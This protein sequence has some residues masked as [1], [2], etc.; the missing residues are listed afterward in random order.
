[1]IHFFVLMFLVFFRL[2]VG[3]GSPL[4]LPEVSDPDSKENAA[5]GTLNSLIDAYFAVPWFRQR[6]AV[7]SISFL[8]DIVKSRLQVPKKRWGFRWFLVLQVFFCVSCL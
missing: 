7:F 8:G 6:T 4:L 5:D 3:G 1:M 2:F